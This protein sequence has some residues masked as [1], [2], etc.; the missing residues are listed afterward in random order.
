M[1]NGPGEINAELAKA[2]FV[3]SVQ[4]TQQPAPV[5]PVAAEKIDITQPADQVSLSPQAREVQALVAKVN[6][7]PEIREER[8][9]EIQTKAA[10]QIR[11]VENNT[12]SA[13]KV[14]EKLLLE[15]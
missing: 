15:N 4:N 3:G 1:I 6:I 12:D 11:S 14:A 13:A 7:L 5:A 8:L 9:V 2:A 10:Q